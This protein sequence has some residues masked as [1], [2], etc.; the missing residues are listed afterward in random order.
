M[1]VSRQ[2]FGAAVFRRFTD[3]EEILKRAP[4]RESEKVDRKTQ[5]MDMISNESAAGRRR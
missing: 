3:K 5:L 2:D 1:E 4:R